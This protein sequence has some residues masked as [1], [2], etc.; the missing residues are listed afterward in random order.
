MARRRTKGPTPR[1]RPLEAAP[2]E[3]PPAGG[4]EG[5]EPPEAGGREA[6]SGDPLRKV[7]MAARRSARAAQLLDQAVDEA[8][9]AG[10]SWER[11]GS[12]AGYSG[13]G[14]RARSERRGG[15]SGAAT[16]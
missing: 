1:R 3:V 11:I 15:A 6:P 2:E 14:L 13:E 10:W 4:P 8:R 12:A 5:A 7:R 9:A 16:E